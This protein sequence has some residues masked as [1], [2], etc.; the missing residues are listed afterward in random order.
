[1]NDI[2]QRLRSATRGLR[3]HFALWRMRRTVAK[4]SQRVGVDLMPIIHR[5]IASYEDLGSAVEDYWPLDSGDDFDACLR[6][7]IVE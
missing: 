3:L 5:A 4:F 2:F 7:R 1:M 6:R